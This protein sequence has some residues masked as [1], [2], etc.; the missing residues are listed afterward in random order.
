MIVFE[1][2]Q[3]GKRTSASSVTGSPAN[4]AYHLTEE[5]ERDET[6][7]GSKLKGAPGFGHAVHYRY[8]KVVC[9]N[10]SQASRDG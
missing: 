2:K 10:A 4:A 3:R 6:V 8:T 7:T 1:L 9:C 5:V